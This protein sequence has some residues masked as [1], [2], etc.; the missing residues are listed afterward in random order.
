M[1]ITCTSDTPMAQLGLLVA[2][3]FIT[4]S[5][6][7]FSS[8]LVIGLTMA[9][10]VHENIQPVIQK[11]T[12]QP[13]VV[14]TTKPVHEVHHNEAK[15][16]QASTLPTVSMSDFQKQGGS[17]GGSATR[18]DAFHGEPQSHSSGYIGGHGA[19]GTTSVTA[20]DGV[21]GSHAGH[22]HGTTGTGHTHGTPGAGTGTGTT[23]GTGTSTGLAGAPTT[24]AHGTKHSKPSLMDKLNPKKDADGDGKAGFLD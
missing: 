21:H 3:T 16:H 18:T 15:H 23:T 4:V 10:D 22:T 24:G 6:V 14:H 9:A 11:E 17:L 2:S 8:W 7:S 5:S 12:V 13:S 20:K 19:Q 1:L